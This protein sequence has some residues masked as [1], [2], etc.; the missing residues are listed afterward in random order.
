MKGLEKAEMPEM[1]EEEG[2]DAELDASVDDL[3]S[4]IKSGDTELAKMALK[5][6]VMACQEYK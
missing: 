6:A 5:A 1:E 4:A 3:L 2:E